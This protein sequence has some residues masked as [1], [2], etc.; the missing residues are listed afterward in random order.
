MT[1]RASLPEPL[2]S[3]LGGGAEATYTP[4]EWT[5]RC[6]SNLGTPVLCTALS[7]AGTPDARERVALDLNATT[8]NGLG[9]QHFVHGARIAWSVD[10]VRRLAQASSAIPA[11][12][13]A[14]YDANRAFA[15]GIDHAVLSDWIT[16]PVCGLPAANAIQGPAT[17]RCVALDSDCR[18]G[19]FDAARGCCAEWD[20]FAGMVCGEDGGGADSAHRDGDDLHA[21]HAHDELAHASPTGSRMCDGGGGCVDPSMVPTVGR[22]HG[23]Y[24]WV[25]PVRLDAAPPPTPSIWYLNDTQIEIRLDEAPVAIVPASQ[26]GHRTR[27]AA[28]PAGDIGVVGL[29]LSTASD[30]AVR[31]LVLPRRITL[32]VDVA[33][34]GT[35][36]V[37]VAT[38]SFDAMGTLVGEC[39]GNERVTCPSAAG[40][41]ITCTVDPRGFSVLTA[42]GL[43]VAWERDPPPNC[44]CGTAMLLTG[45]LVCIPCSLHC[46]CGAYPTPS[47][48]VCNGCPDAAPPDAGMDASTPP[49]TAV[50]DPVLVG[51]FVNFRS[52]FIEPI[53]ANCTCGS[54]P[55]C[56]VGPDC[57]QIRTCSHGVWGA[58]Q[59]VTLEICNGLDDDCDGAIDEN[60]NA[61]CDDGV[62]CTFDDCHGASG[63]VNIA[64]P[65]TCVGPG[66]R[67]GC[68]EPICAGT[69][70]AVDPRDTATAGPF[71][72]GCGF[73]Q[74]SSWCT[75]VWDGCECNG[76]ELCSPLN[77]ASDPAS[78]CF[79]PPRFSPPTFAP[80]AA[81]IVHNP[82]DRDSN[83]CTDE[84]ICCEPNAS[85]RFLDPTRRNLYIDAGH[86]YDSRVNICDRIDEETAFGVGTYFDGTP[87]FDGLP[88]IGVLINPD[89]DPPGVPDEADCLA[90]QL[91]STALTDAGRWR[92]CPPDGNPCTVPGPMGLCNPATRNC[93]AE[94]PL[95]P[96]GIPA[97]GELV[98]GPLS[99][100]S[101]L[102]SVGFE[103]LRGPTCGGD[104]MFVVPGGG[105]VPTCFTETCLAGRCVEA[106][107]HSSLCPPFQTSAGVVCGGSH[108]EC[109]DSTIL[110]SACPNHW[111]ELSCD[112]D[113]ANNCS[114]DST[115]GNCAGVPASLPTLWQTP[116]SP[117][118]MSPV[119]CHSTGACLINDTC[120]AQFDPYPYNGCRICQG[121]ANAYDWTVLPVGSPCSAVAS[122]DGLAPPCDSAHPCHCNASLQCVH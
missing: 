73:V 40:A 13:L 33:T 22:M 26:A 94:V 72:T 89:R 49:F 47:G 110:S 41:L 93:I 107:P 109:N 76:S 55:A 103:G 79:S 106:V 59:S 1:R 39:E 114:W 10:D 88:D 95:T 34:G 35:Y 102:I 118:A 91:P 74:R 100:G 50:R 38:G 63:C 57:F 48:L 77:P 60:P 78:G 19:R 44:P 80:S 45:E 96:N 52:L 116:P 18:R 112:G 9:A 7:R 4:D 70:V 37:C 46:G 5:G 108:P 65:V 99:I 30:S 53:C 43:S 21:D 90:F 121:L 2:R 16:T 111:D 56:N 6:A 67:V 115:R 69:I 23:V 51:R 8:V 86:I 82:C 12:T 71:G 62:S 42:P 36:E 97:A 61:L 75:D 15:D 87:N 58:C 122:I 85:C 20:M 64:R 28:S 119:G 27:V 83:P 54:M 3:A 29:D 17:S 92:V 32:D 66:G 68:V 11:V 31:S 14:V 98:V 24:S 101:G 104:P 117:T 120:F 105:F 81:P 25:E 113:A 84:F